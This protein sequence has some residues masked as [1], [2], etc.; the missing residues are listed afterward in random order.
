M[1]HNKQLNELSLDE[2]MQEARRTQDNIKSVSAKLANACVTGVAGKQDVQIR[3]NGKY[4]AIST[5]ISDSACGN[6]E[7]LEKLVTIAINDA[8]SKL[9]LIAKE[10]LNL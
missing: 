3:I 8:F 1:L 10:K 6:K 7:Q 9:E 5:T 2:L 4:Q